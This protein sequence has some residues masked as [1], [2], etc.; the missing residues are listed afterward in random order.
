VTSLFLENWWFCRFG[1][2][3]SGEYPVS[4]LRGSPKIT[5]FQN[6]FLTNQFVTQ[7]SPDIMN[8]ITGNVGTIVSFRV[9]SIV[10]EFLERDFLPVFNRYDLMN[11]PNFNT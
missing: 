7:V 8:A 6:L 10:G 3:F 11:L 4:L 5:N 2:K 9:G 1:Q